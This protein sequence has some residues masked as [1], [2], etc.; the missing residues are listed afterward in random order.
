MQNAEM[1]SALG[2]N[3][4]HVYAATFAFGAA[5]TG[6][7]G[8]LIAPI[9]GV[10]PTIGASYIAKAFITVI[11]GGPAPVLGTASASTVYGLVSQIVTFQTTPVIGQAALL[12]SAIILLRL[13]PRGISEVLFRGSL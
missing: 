13:L 3:P 7:A 4:S 5:L 11:S 9:T 12:I 10:V 1:A 6:L 2:V 8:G